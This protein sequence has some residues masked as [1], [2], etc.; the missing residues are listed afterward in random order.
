MNRARTLFLVAILASLSACK[1]KAD[2]CNAFVEEAGK[3]QEALGDN[4]K[5]DAFKAAAAKIDESAKRLD[6]LKID[7]KQLTGFRTRYVEGIVL[8]SKALVQFAD[9]VNDPAKQADAEKAK[10]DLDAV[11]QR[12]K[13]LID[14]INAYCQ[15]K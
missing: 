12:E 10:K 8:T 2:Q 5:P 1:S 11:E 14:E 4:V 6:A 13:K 9:S 7:D 15:S 3:S